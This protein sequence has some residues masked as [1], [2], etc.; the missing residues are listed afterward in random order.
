MVWYG[1]VW[2]GMV[3]YGM[4][5][6]SMVWYGIEGDG[7]CYT[8]WWVSTVSYGMT[9]YIFGTVWRATVHDMVRCGKDRSTVLVGVCLSCCIFPA[10][11]ILIHRP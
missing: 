9:L 2:Y 3:W 5:W 4:R 10:A 1:T 7:A 8:V 6:R 11:V